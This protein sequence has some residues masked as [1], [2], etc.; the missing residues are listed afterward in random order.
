MVADIAKTILCTPFCHAADIR[1][2]FLLK[3]NKDI[4]RPGL[5]LESLE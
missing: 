2:F 5:S 3:K 1:G 4:L